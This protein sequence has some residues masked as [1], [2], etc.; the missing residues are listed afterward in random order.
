M[1]KQETLAR[2]AE[3]EA[4]IKEL[5]KEREALRIE[6][7]KN[8]WARWTISIRMTAPNL[9]WWKENKPRT[10]EKYTTPSKVKRFEVIAD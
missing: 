1:N 2:I 8:G 5:G 4:Q 10:W 7:V 3:V 6:A 9:T